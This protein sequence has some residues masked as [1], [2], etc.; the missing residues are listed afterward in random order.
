LPRAPDNDDEIS[1]DVWGF[2]DTRFRI[3]EQGQVEMTGTRYELC[4][5]PL[6]RLLPWVREVMGIEVDPADERRWGEPRV[7]APRDNPGLAARLA[8]LL[9]PDQLSADPRV[10]LRR[11]HGHTQ[12]E[13]YA[14][15]FGSLPR[16]PDLVA[17]PETE[18]EVAAIVEAAARH[19][20]CVVPYGGGTNVSHAL[21][22]PAG[23]ERFVLSVDLGRMN[24]VRWVDAENRLACIEAGAVGR[25]I[26][27]ELEA[28]GFTMGHEPD[29]VE[30]STLGGWIAT[31]ASGMKKNR[32]GNIEDLV[33]DCTVVTAGGRLERRTVSP[34]E[35]TG[36]APWKWVFGS[37]GT[38][39]IVTSAVV[40]I[41]P[42]PE[43]RRYGSVLFP[44]FSDGVTF[45]RDLAAAGDWPASARL[46]DNLQFQF[47]QALKPEPRG[48]GAAKSRAEKWFVTRL[49]G[50]RPDRM[51]AATFVYEGS[52]EETARQEALVEKLARRHGG[53]PAGSENGRRGYQLTFAIAYIRDFVM[54]HHV[55]GESFETSVPWSR[56]QELCENVK[57]RIW[58]QH[59]KL[60]LP[61]RPFVSCRVT[62]I[63]DT[64]ACVYFYFAFGHQGVE[65]PS[66]VYHRIETAAR[67]E[68]LRSGGTL[69]H[70]HG[71][72]KLRQEFLP[73][74][75]SAETH[76]WKRR[77]KAAVDPANVFG[78]ANQGISP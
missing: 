16:V 48:L 51:S 78:S 1:T 41:F 28:R 37:E 49:K 66:H 53:M 11:G 76:E 35:S 77:L 71:V 17:F 50:F 10:R 18:D 70:H 40:K 14:V 36:L 19:G 31:H 56:V 65:N 4:G 59:Q 25:N 62:Q 60:G 39:G 7:P 44:S 6:T 13:M 24:R 75:H 8:G 73:R 15:K 46:V 38:L 21:K 69:S 57:G 32:Y 63:Y 42:L 26:M 23:E 22:L 61:G 45:M 3:N 58:E 64:G 12:E 55:L 33:L 30:F 29:S 5:A 72:G 9:R 2:R 27:A 34:R 43:V 47:G 67:E 52:R 74:E 68:I 20:A 54:R